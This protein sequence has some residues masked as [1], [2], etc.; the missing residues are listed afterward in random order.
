MTE[1]RAD[2]H[3]HTTYSDGSLSP[4]ELV[5]HA[6]KSGLS[7]LSITDHDTIEAY[8]TAIPVCKEVGIEWISG[9]E[10]SSAYNEA[11]VHIL[12]YAF[13]LNSPDIQSFC[14][15]HGHRRL[16]RNRIIL[17]LLAKNGMPISEQ[18]VIEGAPAVSSLHRSFGRPH[19]AQ[20]MIRKGYVA[21]VQEAFKKYLSEG[22]S[23]YAQGE[24]FSVEETLA[25]I[26]SA[27]GL[28]VIAHPHLITRN[29]TIKYLLNMPFDG[30]ECFYGKFQNKEH[31]RWLTI[32]NKKNWLI[33][34]GS[35]F[36]G[37]IKPIIELGC[38]WIGE[39]TFR[40]LQKH[41]LANI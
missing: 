33:T 32:A 7:G 1:F 15:Q 2:L 23:C 34:G 25:T 11:S 8:A 13:P 4:G 21:T 36:H 30:L 41:F 22:T 9:V 29:S 31:T 40:I 5:R 39:D 14:E 6:K 27:R 3:C 38:S 16:N 24:F 37:D 28:A 35:D 17:E 20:A 19:I 10:F 18:E 26:H 12:G